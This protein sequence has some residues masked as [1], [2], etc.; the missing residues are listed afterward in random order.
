V[1]F[2]PGYKRYALALL[3]AV[4][5]LNLV[6]R[7]LMSL[8]LQ[9]IK[10]DLALTDTQL[11]FISGIAFGLFYALVGVPLA[12]WADR[13]NRVH[14]AALAIGVWGLTV[15]TCL[16]VVNY[17]QLVFARMAAA[18]GESGC[19][20][21]SYSLLGDYFPERIERA[22]AMSM[23]TAANYVSGLMSGVV[24]G[25][26]NEIYGWRMTFFLMGIPGLVLAILVKL[27]IREPRTQ[28]VQTPAWRALS[29]PSL[30]SVLVFAW[31]ERS[32]RHLSVALIL[33]YTMTL[34]LGP[35][36]AVF[37][38]RSHAMGTAEL[39]LWSGLIF[40][41]GGM[42]GA[43]LNGFA[44]R[45]W[46][47]RNERRHIHLTAL[48]VGTTTPFFVAFLLLPQK[49]WALLALVPSTV[50]FGAF[51]GSI[52]AL[53]QR[54]VPDEMRA[55]MLSVVMLL[56]NL[57][58]FGIGPQ[59]VGILSD[60]LRSLYGADSLRYAMLV[61]SFLG[62]WGAYHFWRIGNTL[63]HDLEALPRDRTR[64]QAMR[65]GQG[66][67]DARSTGTVRLRAE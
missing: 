44:V 41:L 24:G 64:P 39:G 31:R 10:I 16:F 40:A 63:E 25:W 6:D 48:A 22:H 36:Q 50:I 55:T 14:I 15:M 66:A 1:S 2:S 18:I 58:G 3:S 49:H 46:C 61:M 45:R 12:R 19:K 8:L 5:M 37:M 57:I 20:P 47:S 42:A 34:G 65:M 11:G 43:L 52:Y 9:P 59:T 32:L 23:Y 28:A 21:P 38:M 7:G 29:A 51:L 67:E 26:L 17:V 30:K 4:Y 54:L 62:L 35:W 56:T 33:L 53:M 27:T 13:G 60:A